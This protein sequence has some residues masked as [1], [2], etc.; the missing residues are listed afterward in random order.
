MKATGFMAAYLG[1]GGLRR[2]AVAERRE[3]GR[4][5][6]CQQLAEAVFAEADGHE[7]L[8]DVQVG[9]AV[10]LDE[11]WP[12]GKDG[13]VPADHH[14]I[15]EMAVGLGG[16]RFNLVPKRQRASFNRRAR[17]RMDRKPAEARIAAE[18]AGRPERSRVNVD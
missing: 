17:V 9:V 6:M 5:V 2:K 10:A 1:R 13:D 8:E 12:V 3:S 15:G 18:I 16:E 11:D 14:A 4:E 7:A